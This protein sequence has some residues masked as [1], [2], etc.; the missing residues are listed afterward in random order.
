MSTLTENRAKKL[1]KAMRE[2]RRKLTQEHYR[3]LDWLMCI[4][5]NIVLGNDD[6][7][8]EFIKQLTGYIEKLAFLMG[9]RK[10]KHMERLAAQKTA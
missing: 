2:R 3:I 9:E 1:R 10:Q 8:T 5:D 7:A 4:S 6:E